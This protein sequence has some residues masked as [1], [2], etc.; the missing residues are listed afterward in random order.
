MIPENLIQVLPQ[1]SG[2]GC[3][4]LGIVPV[5]RALGIENKIPADFNP[6]PKTNPT[7]DLSGAK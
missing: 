2:Y 4:E 1:T 5:D 3:R 6:R 7:T